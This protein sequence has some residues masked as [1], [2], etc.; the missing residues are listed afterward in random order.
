MIERTQQ[1]QQ[2][3]LA[4]RNQALLQAN[5]LAAQREQALAQAQYLHGVHDGLAEAM[6]LSEDEEGATATP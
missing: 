2:E 1:R 3:L 6:A 4:L 5:D